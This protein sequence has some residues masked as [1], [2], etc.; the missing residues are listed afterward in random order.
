MEFLAIGI[1]IASASF[2]EALVVK[3]TIEGV[4]RQPESAGTLRTLMI[5]GAALVETG[6]IF[7]FILGLLLWIKM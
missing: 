3:A 2:G 6:I 4:A 7:A 5:I 1:A